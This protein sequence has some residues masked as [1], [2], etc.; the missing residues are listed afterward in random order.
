MRHRIGLVLQESFLM[1]GTIGENIAYGKLN[2]TQAEIEHAARQAYI[3]NFVMTLPKGY[4]T[5]I[6][7][8]GNTLSGGQ[9]Q[10][11]AVAVPWSS[12]RRF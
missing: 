4:H 1:R 11:M 9:R 7:E 3:H 10:R 12:S 5:V 2:A 8:L 6:G